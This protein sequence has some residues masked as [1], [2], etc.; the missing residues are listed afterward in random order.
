MANTTSIVLP[1]PNSNILPLNFC[2]RCRRI[3]DTISTYPRWPSPRVAPLDPRSIAYPRL[4]AT[5]RLDNPAIFLEFHNI[6]TLQFSERHG[7]HLC[8]LIVHELSPA[9]TI[10]FHNELV[11]NPEKAH[12]QL[13]VLVWR[14]DE[15]LVV[16]LQ[17]RIEPDMFAPRPLLDF[18]Y[19]EVDQQPAYRMYESIRMLIFR[20]T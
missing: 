4:D 19:C 1:G 3:F 12:D 17:A 5:Q 18:Q 15:Q 6:R 7:C 20:L 13:N 16:R 2:D 8:K 10:A 14:V 11:K 9:D